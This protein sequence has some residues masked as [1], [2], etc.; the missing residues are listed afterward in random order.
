[1]K[2]DALEYIR[3]RISRAEETLQVAKLALENDFLLDTV[4]R[5]YY[6]C[7]FAVSALLLT[8]ERS[9]SRH[10]G[11]HFSVSTGSTRG[12]YPLEWGASSIGFTNTDRKAITQT[13]Y[14]LSVPMSRRD[15]RRPQPSSRELLRRSRNS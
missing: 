9:S 11:A 10:T 6:A 14:P 7:F 12:N 3:Y 13:L 15:L 4:N 2:A 8:E 1:M 5:L